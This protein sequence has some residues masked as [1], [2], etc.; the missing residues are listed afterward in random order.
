VPGI[1]VCD[2]T[3]FGKISTDMMT[4]DGVATPVFTEEVSEWF[5]SASARIIAMA[6]NDG[7]AGS[8]YAEEGLNSGKGPEGE[9]DGGFV[10]AEAYAHEGHAA[11]GLQCSP[12]RQATPL[13]IVKGEVV[14]NEGHRTAP[15]FRR[16]VG[17]LGDG[18]ES[19]NWHAARS[20][21]VTVFT[22]SG[23]GVAG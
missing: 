16:Y 18:D 4:S 6:V 22:N 17:I 11:R 19:I 15:P 21:A 12:M 14:S 10:I 13:G 3:S 20:S 5:I 2:F 23:A 1:R 9:V 7:E 8:N